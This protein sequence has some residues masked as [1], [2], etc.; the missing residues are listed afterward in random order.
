MTDKTAE[1]EES[2]LARSMV[3]D[4]L[5][6]GQ[7]YEGVRRDD[8]GSEHHAGR[9]ELRTRV[10]AHQHGEDERHEERE[11]HHDPEMTG[12]FRPTAMS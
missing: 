6:P 7:Y 10:V 5:M 1:I 3:P 12:H 9:F 8:E 11:Q 4:A 2:A